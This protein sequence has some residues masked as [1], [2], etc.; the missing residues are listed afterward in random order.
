L[1]H[2]PQASALLAGHAGVG[3]QG[4]PT[5]RMPEAVQ[6]L[7]T[8]GQ[9]V[10]E[11]DQRGDRCAGFNAGKQKVRRSRMIRWFGRCSVRR[12]ARA[13]QMVGKLGEDGDGRIDPRGPVDGLTGRGER[14]FRGD[15]ATPRDVRPLPGAALPCCRSP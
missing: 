11:G 4:L 8:A 12:R 1:K 3:W 14:G 9:I 13:Q 15:I 5:V 2:Q 7:D 6:G 10:V